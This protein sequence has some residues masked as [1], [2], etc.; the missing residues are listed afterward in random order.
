M[1]VLTQNK[2]LGPGD[3]C[4]YIRDA[5]NVLITPYSI[6]YSIYTN[7]DEGSGQS[8]VAL[9]MNQTPANPSTGV[10]Y[11][12]ITIPTSWYGSL[13]LIWSIQQYSASDPV[14]TH[15]EDIFIEFVAPGDSSMEAASVITAL[16]PSL[17]K[18]VA[19]KVMMVRELLSDK[20]PNRDYHFQP[21]TSARTI[22]GYSTRSGFIWLDSTIIRMLELTISQLNWWNPKTTFGFN[23]K[24]IPQDWANIVAVGAAAKCL[25]AEGARWAGEQFSYSLNGVSLSIDKTGYYQSLASAYQA[26]FETMAP[27]VTANRP[28]SAGV[29]QLRYM[30]G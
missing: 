28:F 20:N 9:L 17:D 8:P 29:R 10:Y 21:P 6:T 30:L 27:L 16:T 14:S 12:N 1:T 13:R 23:I 11:V 26:E 19:S 4:L 18:C 25:S 3:L 7:P 24:T 5:N 22:A 2:T 15:Y